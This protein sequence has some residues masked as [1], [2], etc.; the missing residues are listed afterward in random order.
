MVKNFSIYHLGPALAY[1]LNKY[2]TST[3]AREKAEFLLKHRVIARGQPVMCV[4]GEIDCRVH[5]LRQAEKY[6]GDFRPVIDGITSNYLEFLQYVSREN[7]IYVWGPVA[8]QNDSVEID[9]TYPRY[10][11]EV[12]RNKTTEYFNDRMKEIC[13]E[14]GF[15]F[16][17]IFSSLIDSNYRTK[18]EYIAD[19]CHLSQRAW[20][21]ATEEFRK[22]GIDIAFMPEDKR[23]SPN[24]S[25]RGLWRRIRGR[26]SSYKPVL[27]YYFRKLLC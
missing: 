10:G 27:R 8:S 25:G 7:P 3:Q 4:F 19:T 1:N 15:K 12:E 20:E 6:G 24:K 5:V 11:A 2:G 14:H 23:P 17:S 18:Y 26:L 22:Q 21:F 9:T 16:F 13:R